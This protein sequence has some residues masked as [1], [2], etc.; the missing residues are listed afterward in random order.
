[1]R[2]SSSVYGLPNSPRAFNQEIHKHLIKIGFTASAIDPCIYYRINSGKGADGDPE[3]S[4]LCVVVDDIIFASN[5]N[6]DTFIKEMGK[7]FDLKDLGEP[8]YVLGLRLTR[9][10]KNKTIYLDQQGFVDKVLRLFSISEQMPIKSAP[11]STAPK[12]SSTDCTPQIL[13]RTLSLT[14]S[15]AIHS[16]PSSHR[17]VA[18]KILPPKKL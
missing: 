5:K 8:S 16:T 17:V 1:M 6:P 14:D 13:I 10:K 4:A 18:S 12:A 11:A 3:W 2:V 15:S 9:D 7:R